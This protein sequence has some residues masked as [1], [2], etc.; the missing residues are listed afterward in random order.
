M[1]YRLTVLALCLSFGAVP[2]TAFEL[3]FSWKGLKSC[4][5]GNPNTVANPEFA[6]KDVPAGSKF[7]R[8]KLTDRDVPDYN[9]GGGTVAWNGEGAVPAGAFKYKSPCPPNGPHSYEWTATAM[10]KKN[11]GKL[12]EAKAKREYPE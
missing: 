11:G 10:T 4:T 7:I 12:G 5:S 8:F 1:S 6:L 9:H 3:S 2:A